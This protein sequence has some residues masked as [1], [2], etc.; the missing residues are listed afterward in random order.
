GG[1][2]VDRDKVIQILTQRTDIKDPQLWAEMAPT[3]SSPDGLVNLQSIGESQAYFG[4]L[5][6]VLNTPQ[7]ETLVDTSF[8]QAALKT[9]GPGGREGYVL[10]PLD[11]E[12]VLLAQLFN[13]VPMAEQLSLI[14]DTR[15]AGPDSV[16]MLSDVLS[17]HAR[18]RSIALAGGL[19]FSQ[20]ARL[21][22]LLPEA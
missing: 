9:L 16:A 3:G 10:L 18:G 13:H 22:E 19:P 11:A 5:G 20:Y 21:S 7:P 15:W 4:E 14:G 6:M 17:A 8:T 2:A 12:R 1:N